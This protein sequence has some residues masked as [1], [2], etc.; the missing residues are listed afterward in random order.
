MIGSNQ[1]SLHLQKVTVQKPLMIFFFFKQNLTQFSHCIINKTLSDCDEH[2]DNLLTVWNLTV[3]GIDSTAKKK[4]KK[5]KIKFDFLLLGSVM[6]LPKALSLK[7]WKLLMVVVPFNLSF[8]FRAP[9]K[10]ECSTVDCPSSAKGASSS[11]C[12]STA[13]QDKNRQQQK[14]AWENQESAPTGR[15]A[16]YSSWWQWGYSHLG[17]LPAKWNS[18]K[19]CVHH[20]IETESQRRLLWCDD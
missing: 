12:H 7:H 1:S 10:F 19:W 18:K 6:T 9:F 14:T 4:K 11:L 8:N 3:H 5:A 20:S 17:P 16:V 13:I 2:F 15:K